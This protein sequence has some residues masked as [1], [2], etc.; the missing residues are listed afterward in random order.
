VGHTL[1][2]IIK[3]G[4]T[5]YPA[6][7]GDFGNV[8][9][10]GLTAAMSVLFD[11]NS[12]YG[13]LSTA[14]SA[15][16]AGS[17]SGRIA[18]L[19]RGD[20]DFTVKL[21]NVQAAG[22]LGA[23]V[24]NREAGEP[25]VM[26]QNGAPTQPTIPGFMVGLDKRADLMT[27]DGQT[28]TLPELETYVHDPAKDDI[29][30]DFTSWGPTDVDFRV[31]PDVMAPGVNVLSSIP[32]SY[33]GGAPCFA[34]FNGTSMATPHLA[35]SA[36][37]LRQQNPGWSAADIRSA[38]VNTAQ[39]GVIK[40]PDGSLVTDVNITGAGREDLLAAAQA[41]VTLSPVSLSF[42][43]VPSGSGQTRQLPIALTNVTSA[44]QTYGLA[45]SGGS[46]GVSYGLSTS[47]V[48][49]APG[50]SATVTVTMAASQGVSSGGK[51][52]ALEVSTTGPVAHAVLYTQV[53]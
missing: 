50:E 40:N 23:I 19:S 1:V 5:D 42:G 35:G 14:C 8:P 43:A 13:G 2:S 21:L 30:A 52:A 16:A 48:K 27:K 25:F 9:A 28:A 17:L 4:T 20:C 12:I 32:R 39:R 47:S 33:C 51:Q 7:K 46:A 24:V 41:Q 3:V 38:I 18:L 31:K 22:A 45:I 37:V 34:F 6:V 36:A 49:V 15:L 11:A 53:K 26:G 44:W 29:V 10:G